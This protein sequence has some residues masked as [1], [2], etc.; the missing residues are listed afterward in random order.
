MRVGL[1]IYGDL[2]SQSGGYLYDRKLVTYLQQQGDSV[3]VIS[4]PH[5]PYWQEL[6]TRHNVKELVKTKLDVLI[7]DELVHPSVFR[8]NIS[9]RQRTGIPVVGLVHLFSAYAQQ[10]LYRAW[11]YRYIERCYLQS[12][13]GL[14][15]NSRN[16]L[17]QAS[18]LIGDGL[19][20]P[21]VVAVPA[22]NNF[23]DLKIP[24]S[25]RPALASGPLKILCVGNVISQKGVHVLLKALHSLPPQDF[26]LTI[27]GRL[28][29]EPNYVKDI[30][31]AIQRLRLQQ[32][33]SMIGPLNSEQLAG[34]YQSHHIF[35]LPSVNE[36]YGIVYVEAQQFGLPVIGTTA[37]GAGEIIEHG[38]NG[39][40]ITPGDST[41]LAGLLGTLNKDRELLQ[42]L[43]ANALQAYRQHPVWEDTGRTIRAFLLGLVSH[44]KGVH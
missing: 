11:L 37:G 14:I 22:G 2:D 32:Q 28:D 13:D 9:L 25:S 4:L 38:N 31:T 34:I 33:V 6:C 12:L 43:G 8:T 5:R 35:V 17:N 24:D 30:E 20:P 21:H 36:A 40:L 16:S 44:N 27:A 41:A 42:A 39:Y 15:L 3:E 26:Q 10:P 19:L 23:D 29:M 1:L 7:Q 18:E